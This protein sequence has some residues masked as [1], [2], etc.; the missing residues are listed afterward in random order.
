M[1]RKVAMMKDSTRDPRIILLTNCRRHTAS[2][3]DACTVS[4][5]WTWIRKGKK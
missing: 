2:K 3:E 5:V 4:T 1:S